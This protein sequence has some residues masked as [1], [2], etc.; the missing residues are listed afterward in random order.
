MMVMI[1]ARLTPRT[2]KTCH[3]K[4]MGKRMAPLRAPKLGEEGGWVW[5]QGGLET[6]RRTRCA[7]PA[8]PVRGAEVTADGRAEPRTHAQGTHAGAREL[9][10]GEALAAATGHAAREV[11]QD[12]HGRQRRRARWRR[13]GGE[14]AVRLALKQAR[15]MPVRLVRLRGCGEIVSNGQKKHTHE[16][17]HRQGRSCTSTSGYFRGLQSTSL[18]CPS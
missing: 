12:G 10:P 16:F 1:M 3:R 6:R 13:G 11:R 7:K 2:P 17:S 5:E 18:P 4:M 14:R 15:R 9:P 8:Q